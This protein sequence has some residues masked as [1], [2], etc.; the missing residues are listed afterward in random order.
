VLIVLCALAVNARNS[1]VTPASA[2]TLQTTQAPA[3]VVTMEN[4]VLTNEKKDCYIPRDIIINTIT[5]AL[6]VK[7]L[8]SHRKYSKILL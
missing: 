1:D 6:S 5:E 3:S 2:R 4:A 8:D 7:V